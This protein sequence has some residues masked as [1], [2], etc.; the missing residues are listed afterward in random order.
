MT[1]YHLHNSDY[2]EHVGRPSQ[3]KRGDQF[4]LPDGLTAFQG[5]GCRGMKC[6]IIPAGD[7]KV[8]SRKHFVGG[9]QEIAPC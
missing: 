9:T 1:T 4:T 5:P 8:V 3:A 6:V 2:L 7:Y